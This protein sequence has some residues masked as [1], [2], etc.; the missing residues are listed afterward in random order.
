MPIFYIRQSRYT[1]V[2]LL[3]THIFICFI[4]SM[5]FSPLWGRSFRENVWKHMRTTP[6]K[7]PAKS[8]KLSLRIHLYFLGIILCA[9]FSNQAKKVFGLMQFKIQLDVLWFI[10]L[11]NLTLR[12]QMILFQRL[13][14]MCEFKYMP[15]RSGIRYVSY[16][17]RSNFNSFIKQALK[18]QKTWGT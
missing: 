5:T 6:F 2:K 8:E 15:L 13:N 9:Q 4:D 16:L 1:K 3:T 7:Q 14:A 11:Y 17:P 12:Y 18:E 10:G